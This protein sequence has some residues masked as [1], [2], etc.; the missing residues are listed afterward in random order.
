M[1]KMN[2]SGEMQ[3]KEKGV[4]KGQERDTN[5]TTWGGRD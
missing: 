4:E 3:R 1:V 5:T 2:K